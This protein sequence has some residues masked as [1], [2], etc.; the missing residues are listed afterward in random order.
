MRQLS[1]LPQ[2][3][4]DVPLEPFVV[5]RSDPR[6]PTCLQELAT[7]RYFGLDTE[8]YM[9]SDRD[10]IDSVKANLRLVQCG[11]PS[12]L[13]LVADFGGLFDDRAHLL[14]ENRDFTDALGPRV[15]DPQVLKVGHFL[16]TEA[17]V[18]HRTFGWD[19]RGARCTGLMS[20][21]YWAGLASKRVRRTEHGNVPQAPLRHSLL[22]V[23][24]RLG[25]S[26]DKTEQKSD[27]AGRLTNKQR[28]YAARDTLY[29][30]EIWQ[31]LGPRIR[32][33][34]LLTSVLAECEALPAF[35]EC[36]Q[37]GMPVD[38]EQARADLAVWKEKREEVLR[39]FRERFPSV[40]PGSPEKVAVALSD[41]LGVALY[42][43]GEP[44]KG[45]KQR[46]QP[47]TGDDVLA[48]W[49]KRGSPDYRD[50]VHAL[51]EWRSM[52]KYIQK[53]EEEILPNLVRRDGW[54]FVAGRFAQVASGG[55]GEDAGMGMGRSSCKETINLQNIGKP[56]PTHVEMGCPAIRRC[57][58]PP[59]GHSL[60][61]ADFS[62]A[63]MR[64]AAQASGDP[65]LVDAFTSGKDAHAITASRLAAL[66]GLDWAPE[67]IQKVRKKRGHPDQE[68]ATNLRDVGKTGNYACL[69]LG[70]DDTIKRSGET[71]A[72]PVYM[73]REEAAEVKAAFRE[74]YST[75]YHYQRDTI[76]RANRK[77]LS[78]LDIGVEGEYGEVRALTGRRL[79]LQKDW[80]HPEWRDRGEYS[81]KGTDCVSAVW[82]MT[83]ADALKWAM[84][85]FQEARDAH[86]EWGAWL[87]V[88]VH[89]ELD[90]VCRREHEVTVAATVQSIMRDALRWAGVVDLPVDGEA[91]PESLVAGSWADK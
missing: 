81:V 17:N 48:R 79:L 3:E 20:Q 23:C 51:L 72:E 11:L 32:E 2:I 31:I 18:L 82:M 43:L 49:A 28:N 80:S 71:A 45:G 52:N 46:V 5:L 8:F 42:T 36:E 44:G 38:E 27:W 70:S 29:P 24:E 14:R 55:D 76:R 50:Y 1:F 65:V 33:E 6:W 30:V 84:A 90:V 40:N 54:A 68:L 69:N 47:T 67:H 16:K 25:I 10:P 78:F 91:E 83:E 9:D 61:V 13:V 60:I 77:R 64:I 53:Y 41:A 34:G 74:V 57:F 22:A 35:A 86:P 85:R 4:P 7:C 56:Q 75:L 63:H 26:V 62:Q 58:R 89:D 12:G 88:V 21:V 59:P 66:R 39:P 87:G 73:T 19:L 15:R 37:L